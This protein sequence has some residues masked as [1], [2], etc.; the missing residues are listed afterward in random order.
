MDVNAGQE[1]QSPSP[2]LHQVQQIV[3]DDMAAAS[4]GQAEVLS[5]T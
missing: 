3:A 2:S 1:S 5:K 4:L